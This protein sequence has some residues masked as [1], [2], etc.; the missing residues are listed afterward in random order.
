LIALQQSQQVLARTMDKGDEDTVPLPEE[1][2]GLVAADFYVV[3]GT[4]GQTRLKYVCDV[5]AMRDDRAFT[6]TCH[7]AALP[8]LTMTDAM[9]T[10]YSGV[11]PGSAARAAWQARRSRGWPPPRAARP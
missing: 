6:A 5:A 1:F 4:D 9:P 2:P 8:S 7:D 10:S 3:D 11:S